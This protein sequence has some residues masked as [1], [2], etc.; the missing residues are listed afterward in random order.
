LAS[1]D[2]KRSVNDVLGRPSPT[3]PSKP[4]TLPIPGQSTTTISANIEPDKH[5]AEAPDELM[6][7]DET[8]SACKHHRV[9]NPP[10]QIN[11]IPTNTGGTTGSPP[12]KSSCS[13]SLVSPIEVEETNSVAQPT[14]I[15]NN[16]TTETA[17][18]TRSYTKAI[19]FNLDDSSPT[20]QQSLTRAFNAVL[21]RKHTLFVKI[22]FPTTASKTDP[23]KTARAQLM[24]YMNMI[25]AVDNSAILYRW[26]QKFATESDTCLK[27]SA[28]PTTLTGLQNFAFQFRPN[29]EG[30]DC[31]C[32]I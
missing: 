20:A 14:M 26:E 23:T 16:S 25:L 7:D 29:A 13:T 32:S 15:T 8:P 30:G 21:T 6:L 24:K 9:A 4:A 1:S 3:D 28:L 11:P 12:T 5:A 17:T 10:P 2:P 31:W 18:N 19:G 22:M 27:P